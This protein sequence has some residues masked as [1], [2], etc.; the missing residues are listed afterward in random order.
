MS[1]RRRARLALIAVC[2]ACHG[3]E[4]A[5][6]AGLGT[7]LLASGAEQEAV[8]GDRLPDVVS[9]RV[10]DGSGNAASGIRVDWS[11]RDNGSA[12]PPFSITDS[13]GRATAHWTLGPSSGTHY[14]IARATGYL[15]LSIRAHGTPGPLPLDS[16]RRIELATADG[17]GQ[18]VHPDYLDLRSVSGALHGEFLA[19]TPYP[20]NNSAWENPAFYASHDRIQWTVPYLAFNPVATPAAGYL[21]DPAMVYNATAG[22]IWMY[23]RQ[24]DRENQI[25]LIR[26]GDGV[27]WSAPVLVAH[28]PNHELVSPTV[29]RRSENEWLMW[30]VNGRGGCQGVTSNIDLRRSTNGIDWTD[31]VPV[32]LAASGGLTPW[33]VF[34]RWIPGRNEYWAVYN[35]KNS[36]SCSTPALYLATSPDGMTWQTYPSPVLARGTVPELRDIVYRAAFEYHESSDVITFWFSGAQYDGAQFVWTTM[37]ERQKGATVFAKISAST[38][39]SIRIQPR[40][41]IP[42]LLNPP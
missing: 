37:V 23:Y 1:V 41:K 8:A 10:V 2:V 4:P 29:V 12:E 38:P 42:P 21:S 30:S 14:L 31:P 24:A 16:I 3:D 17:S 35:V 25:Y 20:A 18:T 34:V 27:A 9:V 11:P 28:A 32:S 40:I 26:T 15:A 6:P 13:A 22:E 5:A 7:I 33:H 19:I 36:E 39:A